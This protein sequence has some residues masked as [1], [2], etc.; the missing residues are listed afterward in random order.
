M[1][2]EK[3]PSNYYLRFVGDENISCHVII[4]DFLMVKEIILSSCYDGIAKGERNIL[5]SF[6]D[7]FANGEKNSCQV[8]RIDLLR[9]SSF[10]MLCLV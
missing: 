7:R 2:K 6:Y 1:L 10:M 9:M 8:F 4:T 5:S 3:I